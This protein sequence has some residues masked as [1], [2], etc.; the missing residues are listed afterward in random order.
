MLALVEK[1][2]PAR[3]GSEWLKVFFDHSDARARILAATEAVESRSEKIG[4][5]LVKIRAERAPPYMA[6]PEEWRVT[7]NILSPRSGRNGGTF[8]MEPWISAK[9]RLALL[10]KIGELR[11]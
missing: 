3:T 4:R 1:F 5:A 9:I 2:F 8:S 7:L 10:H 11:S 6:D